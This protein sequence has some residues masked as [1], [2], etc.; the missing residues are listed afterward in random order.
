MRFRGSVWLFIG[1]VGYS[2]LFFK[3]VI[4]RSDRIF[5]LAEHNRAAWR[6]ALWAAPGILSGER[7]P[8]SSE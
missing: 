8:S 4:N 2:E 7:G 6:C 5:P 1:P 3:R